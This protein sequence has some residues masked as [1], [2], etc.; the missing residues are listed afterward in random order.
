MQGGT[1]NL[2][3]SDS[4]G[5]TYWQIYSHGGFSYSAGSENSTKRPNIGSRPK[6]LFLLFFLF[7]FP[8]SVSRFFFFFF[9]RWE[10]YLSSL[11]LRERPFEATKQR[12]LCC[13]SSA[14]A[15]F[16]PLSTAATAAKA[17]EM[18]HWN[19]C[20]RSRSSFASLFLLPIVKYNSYYCF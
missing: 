20:S 7:F 18:F 11:S 19:Y 9:W 4:K 3:G 5:R 14:T 2:N 6:Y 10:G 1:V 16:F 8:F 13:S 17:G 12:F 15:R